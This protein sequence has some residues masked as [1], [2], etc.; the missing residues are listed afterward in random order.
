MNTPLLSIIV[1]V[2]KVELW[3]PACIDSILRQTYQTWELILIDDGSPDRCGTICD[4]YAA[5]DKRIM[6][7]H[8]A[9]AGVSAARNDGLDLAQGDYITFVDSDDEIGSVDTF[10]KNMSF[11]MV[12]PEVDI[13]QFPQTFSDSSIRTDS[14][15]MLQN[16]EAILKG[17]LDLS[18]NKALWGKIY[19]KE[20]FLHIRLPKDFTCGEDFWCL[21]YLLPKAKFVYLSDQGT[22]TY[23]MRADSAIHTFNGKKWIDCYLA[24]FNFLTVLSEHMP[25]SL[26]VLTTYFFR[27]FQ[28]LLSMRIA[29]HNTIK[30]EYAQDLEQYIPPL[31]CLFGNRLTQKNKMW[32]L[33]LKCFGL[34]TCSNLYVRFVLWRVKHFR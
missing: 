9:N 23:N 7:I 8:K 17:L 4:T 30:D 24:D 11:L 14:P 5:K 21:S 25:P 22:Y 10:E 27:V 32:L 3:L 19:K 6:V 1:P 2:Y 33:L 29:N 26:P 34:P 16:K 31:H 13:L 15:N 20:L 18:I 28:C 12:H